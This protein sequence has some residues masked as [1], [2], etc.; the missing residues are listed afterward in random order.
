MYEII[1]QTNRTDIRLTKGDTFAVQ[2]DAIRE[3]TGEIYVPVEG[4]TVRFAMKRCP[5]DD[6]C[7]VYKSIPIDTMILR[8]EADDTKDLDISPYYYDVQITFANGDVD[9][10]IKGYFTLNTEVE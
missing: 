6:E 3:D 2:V 5:S 7:L 1:E 4:D 10:F 9:T 8:L